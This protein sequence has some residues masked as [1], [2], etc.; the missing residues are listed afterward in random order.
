MRKSEPSEAPEHGW[1]L[2]LA[3]KHPYAGGPQHYAAYLEDDAGFEIEIV[4]DELDRH[5]LRSTLHPPRSARDP[6]SNSPRASPARRRFGGPG[7]LMPRFDPHGGPWSLACLTKP[8]AG[9]VA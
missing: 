3:E 6:R 4:A 8:V 7:G 1:R 9:L 2:L 5:R